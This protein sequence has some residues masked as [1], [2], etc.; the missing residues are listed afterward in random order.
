MKHGDKWLAKLNNQ[1]QHFQKPEPYVGHDAFAWGIK[2]EETGGMC[3]KWRSMVG[4]AIVAGVT[5]QVGRTND[6]LTYIWTFT[7]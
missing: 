7:K 6:L 5:F 3:P 4:K 1:L 2:K